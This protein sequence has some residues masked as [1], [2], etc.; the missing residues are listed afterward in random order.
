VWETERER[1]EKSRDGKR[2]QN[3]T[4]HI[5]Y[6][7]SRTQ[8]RKTVIF[9]KMKYGQKD[10]EN[11]RTHRFTNR[12]IHKQTDSQTD[13]FTNRQIHKQTDSQTDKFMNSQA[14]TCK[15]VE[16]NSKSDAIKKN[17]NDILLLI[18]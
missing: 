18:C 3:M 6:H 11:S 4:N 2:G 12:Q 9:S 5:I 7:S 15:I 13:R 10:T 1:V 8:T 14:K 17:K 16:R